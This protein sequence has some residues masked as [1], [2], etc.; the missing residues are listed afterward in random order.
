MKRIVSNRRIGKQLFPEKSF[1]ILIKAVRLLDWSRVLL[2]EKMSEN[3]TYCNVE[4]FQ[5]T[6]TERESHTNIVTFPTERKL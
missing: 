3:E 1:I 2:I 6:E 4:L 5:E